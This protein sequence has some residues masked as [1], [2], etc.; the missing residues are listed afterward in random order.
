MGKQNPFHQN[1]LRGL[2]G[3]MKDGRKVYMELCTQTH[4]HIHTHRQVLIGEKGGEIL[5]K[6]A[7]ER[8]REKKKL[9]NNLV[10]R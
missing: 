9:K 10:D 3:R 8:E 4:T 1:S 6:K 7:N 5:Y 2:V